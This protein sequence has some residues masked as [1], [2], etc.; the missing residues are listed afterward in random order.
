ME[1][2]TDNSQPLHQSQHIQQ[3]P[4]LNKLLELPIVDENSALNILVGFLD[5][6]QKRGCY[7]LEES[8]KIWECI[9]R[10]QVKK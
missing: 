10:F 2:L 9:K 8:H 6:A 5:I 4:L 3:Q 1:N 7:N